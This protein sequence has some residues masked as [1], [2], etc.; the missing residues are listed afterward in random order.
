[1]A[2]DKYSRLFF[3]IGLHDQA[4]VKAS[5]TDHFL[6][7]NGRRSHLP[8]ETN[9]LT[10]H[11]ENST[12]TVLQNA[13]IDWVPFESS[14]SKAHSA[15]KGNGSRANGE[16]RNGG[17]TG[18]W[19]APAGERT[20]TGR[21][22]QPERLRHWAEGPRSTGFQPVWGS[23]CDAGRLGAQ[24][25]RLRHWAEGRGSTDFQ[26]VWGWLT[27]EARTQPERLRYPGAQPKRPCYSALLALDQ[28]HCSGFSTKAALTGFHSMYVLI[29]RSSSPL[30]TQ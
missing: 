22:A 27:S 20:R 24:P 10:C 2:D 25:E 5:D 6:V 28:R 13:L 3:V 21:G 7:G 8:G 23:E 30:R 1:M 14:D 19:S 9:S 4:P 29:L 16:R 15:D 11:V 17:R 18:R 12:S 26:P